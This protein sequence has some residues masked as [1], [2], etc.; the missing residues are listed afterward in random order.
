MLHPTTHASR[1]G[2]WFYHFVESLSLALVLFSMYLVK[3]RFP[4]SY[5]ERS[6]SFGNMNGAWRRPPLV[7]L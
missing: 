4:H 1:S 7:G 5:D 3:L 2:D 6:D